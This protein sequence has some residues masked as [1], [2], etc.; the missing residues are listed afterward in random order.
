MQDLV[1]QGVPASSLLFL[2]FEDDRLQPLDL[3]GAAGIIDAFYAEVPENHDRSTYL[4]LDE[5][6]ALPEW[7]RLVRRL[8]DTRKARLFLTGSSARMLSREIATELRGRSLATEVWPYSFSE[9]LSAREPGKE[10]RLPRP[11]FGQ[12]AL[13]RL[14]PVLLAYL[15][16]GGFPEVY[17]L[18]PAT[19]LRLLQDYVDVVVFRD[20]VERHGITNLT[21]ARYLT[22]TLLRNVGRS[23]SL[24]KLHNDLRSQGRSV[25][26]DTL[27]E[28]LGYFEDA[29][30][31]FP[32]PLHEASPRKAET[33]P[34]KI[35]GIDPGL[36]A[37]FRMGADDLGQR[38]EN[39]LYLDLRRQGCELAYYLTASRREVDFLARYPDGRRELIQACWDAGDPETLR[40]E[41]EA[42]DEAK[43]ELGLEGRIVT[44]GRYLEQ[45]AGPGRQLQ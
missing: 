8:Q 22:R 34:K 1:A 2:N 14:R 36:I 11:P 18:D 42:L 5:V 41:A 28:Y 30:L 9:W 13:D 37:A 17:G 10:M 35:Y 16:E 32:L 40:R 44:M 4:F 15:E 23:L 33:A 31:C 45:Q 27:Y 29:F 21:L 6:H 7:S 24:N 38:F 39:L 26:K 12:R 19:R 43:A 3:K 25:G 20:V